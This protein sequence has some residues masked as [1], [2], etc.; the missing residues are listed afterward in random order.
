MEPDANAARILA[1]ASFV[2]ILLMVAFG[3][4]GYGMPH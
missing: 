3:W 4:M 1:E 2:I